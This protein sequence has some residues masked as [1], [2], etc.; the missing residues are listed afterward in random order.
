[1]NKALIGS[2]ERYAL[3]DGP[4]I[5][6]TVFFK[7]CAL[8]CPWCH[9]PELISTLPESAFNAARC[10][11]CSDCVRACPENAIDLEK[12]DRIKRE[13]CTGCGECAAACPARALEL[14]GRSYE[15]PELIEILLRD[16]LFYETSNG[17]ITLSGG[18]PT[19]QIGFLESLLCS[20]KAEGIHT[21]I[22]TNGFFDWQDFENILPV[23]DL[24]LFDLKAVDE[25]QHIALTGVRNTQILAN[26]AHLAETRP[27]DLVVRV[28]LIPSY[29]ATE[30]NIGAIAALLCGMGVRRCSLLPY[31][32][33]GISKAE[34]IGKTVN[35]DLPHSSMSLEEL[36]KWSRFFAWAELI[37]F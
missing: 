30:E 8:K 25:R 12:P 26:L 34:R 3:H 10:I 9:N 31:H 28:P 20:L 16:R 18:E 24:V 11:G 35:P 21:A 1:M 33:Y 27:E 36:G 29:T 6:T 5:R 22:Q 7:G 14:V 32:P 4:G 13:R 19:Y 15:V 37:K 23:I 2:I 17:G